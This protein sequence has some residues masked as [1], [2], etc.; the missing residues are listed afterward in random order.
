M[1][2]ILP[3]EDAKP[4]VFKVK[5]KTLNW[6]GLQAVSES[7]PDALV[8]QDN[9]LS[10][11]V[12]NLTYALLQKEDIEKMGCPRTIQS[13]KI[14]QLCLEYMSH[15]QEYLENK[16]LDYEAEKVCADK[17]LDK[18]TRSCEI[19]KKVMISTNKESIQKK[20]FVLKDYELMFKELG[21]IQQEVNQVKFSCDICTQGIKAGL[22]SRK[23]KKKKHYKSLYDLQKH[24]SKKH[25][26]H[27]LDLKRYT[28]KRLDGRV[29]QV[30]LSETQLSKLLR[31]ARPYLDKKK[32]MSEKPVS[33]L[34]KL[35]QR[36]KPFLDAKKAQNQKPQSKLSR[37][38]QRARPFLDEIKRKSGLQPRTKESHSKGDL[39]N[40]DYRKKSTLQQKKYK[41]IFESLEDH[42][43]IPISE[44]KSGFEKQ[45][46]NDLKSFFG[47]KLEQYEDKMQD[48]VKNTYFDIY[49]DTKSKATGPKK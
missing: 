3:R 39:A 11:A 10:K 47:D 4:M 2:N 6:K 29:G 7:L 14:F 34:S 37:L 49:E 12:N 38:L 36:A 21:I 24:Y 1:E 40:Y 28:V 35:L 46:I 18:F 9:S 17:A 5:D 23:S 33:K 22:S 32:R 31:R 41:E 48:K 15:T 8:S 43:E 20:K 30:D 45:D 44:Y 13:F 26:G 16:L 25:P 42:S 27:D 19:N